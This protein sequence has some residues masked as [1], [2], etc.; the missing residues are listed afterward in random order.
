LAALKNIVEKRKHQIK[1][2]E[3]AKQVDEQLELARSSS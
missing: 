3:K 1:A 2:E